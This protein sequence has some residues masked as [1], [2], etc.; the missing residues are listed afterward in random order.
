V[1][2]AKTGFLRLFAAR[3][4][5]AEV[6]EYREKWAHETGTPVPAYRE[7]WVSVLHPL[8]TEVSFSRDLLYSRRARPH[9]SPRSAA[10]SGRPGSARRG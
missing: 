1:T 3:H 5:L 8:I 2:L 10:A 7:A 4:V 9:R 6:D